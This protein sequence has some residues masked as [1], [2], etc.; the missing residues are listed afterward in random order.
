MHRTS[1][2]IKLF[3]NFDIVFCF[4]GCIIFLP[5]RVC[6]YLTDLSKI[7]T[8][9]SFVPAFQRKG[10][11][12]ENSTWFDMRLQL[13]FGVFLGHSYIKRLLAQNVYTHAFKDQLCKGFF[14]YFM[15]RSSSI[16]NKMKPPFLSFLQVFMF[17]VDKLDNEAV[18]NIY[19]VHQN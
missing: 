16:I 4:F 8:K 2:K 5:L 3:K 17:P 11:K 14:S 19:Y 12:K 13:F 18:L 1:E 6:G 15:G 10:E 7:C 9:P